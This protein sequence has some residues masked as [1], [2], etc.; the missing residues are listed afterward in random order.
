MPQLGL[1]QDDALY[2]VGAK[3]LAEGHGYRIESLPGRPFQTKYPPMVS[4]IMTLVWR[5][6]PAFPANLKLATLLAWLMLPPCLLAVR[7]LFRDFGFARREVWL[8]TFA[9]AWNPIVG[10]LSTSIMS[11]LLFLT[12]FLGCLLLA[13]KA[14]QPGSRAWVALAAGLIGGLAYLTRTAALPVLIT[15]PLC[16]AYRRQLR[17]GAWFLAGILPA[18]AAWQAWTLTHMLRT[19]DP[20]LLFYTSY[21][22]VQRST[23]RLDDLAQ[24]LWYNSDE[25]LRSLGK[26]LTFDVALMENV[27]LE[28]ILGV[29][30]IVGAVRLVKRAQRLQYAAA[31]AGLASLLL[32]YSFTS[33][34]RLSLPL[35]PLIAMG[36]WTEAKNF[37]VVLRRSWDEARPANRF[38]AVGGAGGLGGVAAVLAA[39]Y[40]IGYGVFLPK[41]YEAC[42]RDLAKHREGYEWIRA[43]TAADETVNA[44]DDPVL[45]LYTGRQALGMPMP[46]SRIYTG[47]TGPAADRFI[48]DVPHAAR[49][50]GLTYLFVTKVDFYREGRAGI[51]WNAVR[52]DPAL[53]K[54]YESAGYAVYRC[55]R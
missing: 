16:F 54:E 25:L 9:F 1:H 17:K 36:F 12:L 10:L 30:A 4:E 11:D 41:I 19:R 20:A 28:R 2:L 32:V 44:Y 46:S 33:D 47:D 49:E 55:S 23:V 18:V 34:E 26:L 24:V 40:A 22:A 43:R 37:G 35:Y 38:L 13:E 31:A 50:R 27:H 21:M 29:A 6:G 15:A 42:E 52:G 51:L 5:F 45:Y 14:L 7:A 39:G 53:R 8:L 3:S 48:R